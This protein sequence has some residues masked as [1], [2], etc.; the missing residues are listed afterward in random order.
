MRPALNGLECTACGNTRMDVVD[1]RR[2]VN[3]V[4]RRRR[5]RCGYRV[6]TF[7]TVSPTSDDSN[8]LINALMLYDKVRSV[9]PAHRQALLAMI[10]SLATRLPQY[11]PPLIPQ[12]EDQKA[13]PPPEIQ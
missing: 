7:E 9:P 8:H 2:G 12:P 13:L 11:A 4:R 6:T 1:S 10:E 3:S 5:C